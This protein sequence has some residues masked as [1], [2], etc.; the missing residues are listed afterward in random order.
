MW[1]HQWRIYIIILFSEQLLIHHP[2]ERWIICCPAWRNFSLNIQRL[3]GITCVTPVAFGASLAMLSLSY[4]SGYISSECPRWWWLLPESVQSKGLKR[5]ESTKLWLRSDEAKELC[6]NIPRQWACL[7]G[8]W[9]IYTS[10]RRN[11]FDICF[12]WNITLLEF[13]L[14]NVA[15]R[16]SVC[17]HPGWWFQIFY[18]VYC[19]PDPWGNDPIWRAYFSN[20]WFNHQLDHLHSLKLTYPLKMMVFQFGI[21]FSRGPIFSGVKMLVSGRVILWIY[22]PQ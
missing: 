13:V 22:F 18:F 17:W 12:I 5:W 3:C 14:G 20:G 11:Y 1:R 10:A 15:M 19:H 16:K 4:E 2:K 8:S 7:I 6:L 21:S 9:K